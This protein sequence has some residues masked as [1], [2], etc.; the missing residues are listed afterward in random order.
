MA[1]LPKPQRSEIQLV[2]PAP[3]PSYRFESSLVSARS[4]GNIGDALDRMAM[5]LAKEQESVIQKEA[6][7]YAIDK[8]L[9]VEQWERIRKDPVELEKYFSGQGRIFKETFMAAQASQLSSEL[10][11][12][13]ENKFDL[14]KKQMEVGNVS[15]EAAIVATRDL[16]DGAVPAVSSMSPEVGLKFRANVAMRGASVYEKAQDIIASQ[17]KVTDKLANDEYVRNIQSIVDDQIS[18]LTASGIPVD[19]KQ[20]ELEIL[21]PARGYAAKHRDIGAF[22]DPAVKAFREAVVSRVLNKI[23]SSLAVDN[24]DVV[25]EALQSDNFNIDVFYSGSYPRPNIKG[26]FNVATGADAL[27]EVPVES[28]NRVNINL[29]A[30]WNYMNAD[31]KKSAREQFNTAFNNRHN[32]ITKTADQQGR[33]YSVATNEFKA[34]VEKKISDLVDKVPGVSAE[35]IGAFI[36]DKRNNFVSI[37][38]S[39]SNPNIIEGFDKAL[40]E[41]GKTVISDF[42]KTMTT[43]QQAAFL[44]GGKIESHGL[45]NKKDYASAVNFLMGSADPTTRAALYKQFNDE[46]VSSNNLK[47]S[48]DA[49][50]EL[51]KNQKAD[52]KVQVAIDFK[53]T[54]QGT[55]ALDELRKIDAVKWM[56]IKKQ[57]EDPPLSDDRPTVKSLV[58]LHGAGKLT[59]DIVL[60][61]FD[62][63]TTNTFEQYMGFALSAIDKNNDAADVL[64]RNTVKYP[65]GA[66]AIV[67]PT[68]A[69]IDAQNA[70]SEIRV[71]FDNAYQFNRSQ[72]GKKGH[73]PWDGYAVMQGLLGGFVKEQKQKSSEAAQGRVDSFKNTY[74]GNA[75]MSN[76][77]IRTEIKKKAANDP[78][79][80]IKE[81]LS[82]RDLEGYLRDIDAAEGK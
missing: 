19:I 59:P 68:A 5:S 44:S 64:L 37:S 46:V 11:V 60:N 49:R 26:T 79:S 24:P 21:K 65:R 53:G 17:I 52:E 42:T 15:P 2:A 55:T 63:L 4:I 73:V 62:K 38:Q 81:K 80:K 14:L 41:V 1:E 72:V 71:R 23:T 18:K 48:I 28:S 20:I 43:S 67:N 3:A 74:I 58:A 12:S 69:Q 7:Q 6:M 39:V 66:E 13:L 35:A 45:A 25:Q 77:E 78:T 57:L 9:T 22:Y 30:E 27:P 16:V 10:Q 33:V 29:Q 61:N 8:R 76:A 34:S 31:E 54:P 50:R 32:L 36:A 82:N 75:P 51:E 47:N 56:Q 40:I 70:Y